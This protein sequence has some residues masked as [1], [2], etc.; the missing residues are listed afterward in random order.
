MSTR[1]PGTEE[2]SDFYDEKRG[3]TPIAISLE[4]EKDRPSSLAAPVE[5]RAKTGLGLW[6]HWRQKGRDLDAV[7]TQQSVFDDPVT[8]E[9]YRPPLQYE[10]AHRFDPKARWTYREERVCHFL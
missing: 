10:N 3:L 4:D 2:K 8:L 1:L 6:G 7:A 9:A 5:D